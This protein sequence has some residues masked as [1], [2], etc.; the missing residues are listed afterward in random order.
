M[1]KTFLATVKTR[2]HG[3]VWQAWVRA[4]AA[5]P[6]AS[7]ILRVALPPLDKRLLKW[8]STRFC[9]TSWLS[10]LDVALLKVPGRRTG[11]V[12]SV[13]L[14]VFPQHG[15]YYVVAS[16]FG[17]PYRPAWYF[18][19]KQAGSVRLRHRGISGEFFVREA[20][21]TE[22]DRLWTRAVA[23][24]PGYARYEARGGAGPVPI[25]LLTP[26]GAVG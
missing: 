22:R 7:N 16:N 11:H 13:P 1:S 14:A 23:T 5:T 24:Y 12:R 18:D 25:L 10:G 19:L 26:A 17:R 21:E 4:L 2:P 15:G 20:T 6:F 3:H 9:L 8:T